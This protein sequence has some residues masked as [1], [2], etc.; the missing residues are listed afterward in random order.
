MVLEKNHLE[1][2]VSRYLRLRSFLFIFNLSMC[3]YSQNFDLKQTVGDLE[4]RLP[5][6]EGARGKNMQKLRQQV[7]TSFLPGRK[8]F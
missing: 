3:L 1:K 6:V 4:H 5:V 2:E 8:F 7:N